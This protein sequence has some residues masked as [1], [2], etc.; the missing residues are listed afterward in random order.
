MW[1]VCHVKQVALFYDAI[2]SCLPKDRSTLR[3]K[4][5]QVIWTKNTHLCG[6]FFFSLPM[7]FL[8][9]GCMIGPKYKKPETP[10]PEEWMAE[11][12]QSI[13][14]EPVDEQLWWESFNDPILNSL[15]EEAFD[16]NLSL[17]AAALRII[18]TRAGKRFS[19]W[20]LGPYVGM[21]A[22]AA[23]TNYSQDVEP[24]IRLTGV[25]N[26]PDLD[27]AFT[28]SNNYYRYG[29]DSF[30]EPDIWGKGRRGIQ[31]ANA[32][33]ELSIANY[34]AMVVSLTAEVAAV[35]VN[36][37]TLQHQLELEK[38]SIYFLSNLNK[39]IEVRVGEQSVNEIDHDLVEILLIDAKAMKV[40]L[41]ADI[42]HS[43]YVL[44]V[45]IG[46]TPDQMDER[47][48][49]PGPTPSAS[50]E[51]SM[52]IPADLLRR[53]PDVRQAERMA[54]MQSA[55]IGISKVE[56]LYPNLSLFGLLGYATSSTNQLSGSSGQNGTYGAGLRWNILL[57]PAT[58]NSIR[59]E[60]AKFQELVMN[61]KQTV[62][63]A[64]QEVESASSAYVAG[65]DRLELLEKKVDI[66]SHAINSALSL[67]NTNSMN[68]A[69]VYDSINNYSKSQRQVAVAQGTVALNL[70]ALYKSLGGGWEI[71]EGTELLQE[72]VKE[73]MKQRSDW[74]TFG[75]KSMLMR[76][77]DK[78]KKEENEE[79]D[80]S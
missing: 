44:A 58:V 6:L 26:E 33:Q 72:E 15:I 76:P 29:F 39:S 7:V 4:I 63:C 19:Y 42:N 21:S 25:K 52:G 34:D 79:K 61:Y 66:S 32:G 28:G 43:I 64:I 45:L 65:K 37:R 9:S 75:G 1:I 51:V 74:K 62:L 49:I 71:K 50:R 17:Q 27:I 8:L 73:E 69:L 36:L 35:Y 12:E 11:Y 40:S 56:A 14:G 31:A 54:A 70:I 41:E 55:Q 60:D 48:R 18:Q 59:A 13:V 77:V 23:H 2:V 22:G 78:E 3:M 24:T 46:K 47:L 5:F 10:I 80:G 20:N 67:Y 16:Q 30:W 53:R 57:Y 38:K 68:F